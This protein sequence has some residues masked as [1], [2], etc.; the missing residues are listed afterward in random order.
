M[1][2]KLHILGWVLFRNQIIWLPKLYFSGIQ[3]NQGNLHEKSYRKV[4]GK[5]NFTYGIYR[6]F[7]I[8]VHAP[9]KFL[10]LSLLSQQFISNCLNS[11][12]L[13]SF[14][15]LLVKLFKLLF[16]IHINI[17]HLYLPSKLEDHGLVPG[18]L[19]SFFFFT[20]PP[21]R[22]I[23]QGSLHQSHYLVFLKG[24]LSGLR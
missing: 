8:Q 12:T 11:K 7:K 18:P 2:L 20:F 9:V 10:T 17:Y 3:I 1:A 4:S 23:L 15:K 14:S 22:P 21:A 6:Q 19:V 24:A 13:L 16:N 5:E